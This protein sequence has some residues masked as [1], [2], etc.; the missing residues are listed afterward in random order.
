[1]LTGEGIFD[2][3]EVGAVGRQVEQVCACRLDR[4][5]NAGVEQA[6]DAGL[7]KALLPASDGRLRLAGRS[8]HAVRA[9]TF[10]RE[11]DDPRPPRVLLRGI[12]IGDDGL[13]SPTIGCGDRD[14]EPF[15]HAEDSHGRNQKGIPS[16]TLLS[17]SIH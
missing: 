1:M 4:V 16:R 8:H 14:G 5:T 10:G 17:R 7:R 6:V 15:A 9:D 12:A 13:K 3:I 2:G 11:K